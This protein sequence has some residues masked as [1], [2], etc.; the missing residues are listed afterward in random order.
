MLGRA[1]RAHWGIENRLHWVL[2]IAFREDDSRFRTGH[3]PENLAIVRHFALNLLRREPG[4]GSIA[5]KRFRA[6][7]DD[8]YLTHSP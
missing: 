1:I 4:R 5:K 7:L 8:R 2:D 3:G 6:A